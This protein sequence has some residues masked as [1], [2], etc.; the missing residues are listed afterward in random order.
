MPTRRGLGDEGEGDASVRGRV[1]RARESDRSAALPRVDG[2]CHLRTHAPQAKTGG[3]RATT[4]TPFDH[5]PYQPNENG[6]SSIAAC[7][8]TGHG[9][10]ARAAYSI[11]SSARAM[12]AR[13]TTRPSVLQVLRLVRA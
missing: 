12:S 7:P 10:A 5:L 2:T 1:R 4:I 9:H 13:G 11:T 8:R 6:C 3:R